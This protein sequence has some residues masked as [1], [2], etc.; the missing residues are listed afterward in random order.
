MHVIRDQAITHQLYAWVE[1]RHAIGIAIQDKSPRIA[2][3]CGTSTAM[4][5][6]KRATMR[7]PLI[8]RIAFVE[9]Y[10]QNFAETS[11]PLKP[12]CLDPAKLS[13]KSGLAEANIVHLHGGHGSGP[14]QPQ[15]RRLHWAE[16]DDAYRPSGGQKLFRHRFMGYVLSATAFSPL[17]H[18]HSAYDAT[19]WL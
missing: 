4:T 10:T 15:K 11:I 17:D 13:F 19:A 9:R 6:A 18:L 3:L 8:H 1:I 7:T 2:T 12:V 16:K 14:W 5:R